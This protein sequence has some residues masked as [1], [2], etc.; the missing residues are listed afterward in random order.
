MAILHIF[1][2]IFY[3]LNFTIKWKYYYKDRKVPRKI[4]EKDQE[5]KTQLILG[6][7]KTR[8][9]TVYQS[10]DSFGYLKIGSI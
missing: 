4:S 1:Y 8:W 6:I 3:R 5:Y 10:I 9:K 2:S 7:S